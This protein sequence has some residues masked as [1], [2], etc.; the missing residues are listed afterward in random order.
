M[1]AGESRHLVGFALPVLGRAASGAEFLQPEACP[2]G[3]SLLLCMLSVWICYLGEIEKCFVLELLFSCLIGITLDTE[4]SLTFSLV[5]CAAEALGKI[6]K[7]LSHS[8]S[9]YL[10]HFPIKGL[11]HYLFCRG[12]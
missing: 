8:I 11:I 9:S 7:K 5:V 12:D 2:V 4:S 6:R 1:L 10:I 3:L